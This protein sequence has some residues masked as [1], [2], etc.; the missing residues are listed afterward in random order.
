LGGLLVIVTAVAIVQLFASRPALPRRW[1]ASMAGVMGLCLLLTYS[2]GSMIGLVVALTLVGVLRYRK[3][4]I[5]LAAGAMLLVLLP[6]TQ[7]YVA[8]LIEGIQGQDLATQ[9]RFGEYKDALILIG[10]YPVLGV[11]FTGTP[12][13]DLYLGV[14]M[15]YLLIAEQV[16]LVGLFLFLVVMATHFVVTTRAWQRAPTGSAVEGYIL[17]YQAALIGALVG[18]V[19]DHFFFN[20]GFIHLVALFWLVMGLGVASARLPATS[21]T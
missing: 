17:A 10:R 4:F 5:L 7:V 6:P 15:L 3:L 8:R 13:I 11:G 21:S 9:M 20:I 18:G 19:F 12:D 2:R 14:S 1:L 16:G